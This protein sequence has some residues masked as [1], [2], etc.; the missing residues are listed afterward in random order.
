MQ[1]VRELL[2][3]T[4][5]PEPYLIDEGIMRLNSVLV[6]GGAPKAYKSFLQNSLI[7]ALVTG[8]PLFGAHRKRHGREELAFVTAKPCRVL[9][10]EQELGDYDLRERIIPM[11][12][13]LPPDQAQ[14]LQSNLYTHSMDHTLQLDKADG[15]Q[16][17]DNMVAQVRPDVL[18][19]DPLIEF[20]TSN[21]NDTQ[22]MHLVMRNL[23]KLR[24]RY[25]LSI[26]MSHHTGKPNENSS[27]SGPDLLRGNSVIYG[28][29][30]TF[31]MSTV[32]SRA[33]GLLNIEAVIRRGKP[34]SPFYV[35]IDWTDLRAKFNCWH[36]RE[37]AKQMSKLVTEDTE[38]TEQ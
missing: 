6:I 13:S 1:T 36:T 33:A 31:L 22:S 30:D 25:Q 8:T 14:L 15:M 12:R 37:T 35:N 18:V 27:R 16:K 19:L 2:T 17:I 11:L 4:F 24:E 3:R 9:L 28:K 10:L 38:E 7:L 32:R 26:S 23:D 20:H 29:G 34:I 21:E 5:P